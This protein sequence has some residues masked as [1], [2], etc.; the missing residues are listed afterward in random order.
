MYGR[1]MEGRVYRVDGG[2]GAATYATAPDVTKL[3]QAQLW[4]HM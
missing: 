4:P 2:G 3:S 1:I